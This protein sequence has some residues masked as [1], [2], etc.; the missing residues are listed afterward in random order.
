MGARNQELI[1]VWR[2]CY[3]SFG[4]E[5][6][7][8]EIGDA[9][10]TDGKAVTCKVWCQPDE[11]FRDG[12]YRL[13]G[14]YQMHPSYGNQF[15]AR[16]WIAEKPA[17]EDS[18]IAYLRQCKG[19]R[20][21]SI[22][23]RVAV[24]LYEKYGASAI[25]R[26]IASPAEAAEGISQWDASKAAIAAEFLGREEHRRC[27]KLELISLFEGRGFPKQTIDRCIKKWGVKAG[28]VVRNDPY[29][30][31]QFRGIGFLAA[32]KLY[33]EMAREKAGTDGTAYLKAL[34]AIKRQGLCLCHEVAQDRGGSTWVHGGIAKAGVRR[35]VANAN[36]D[37]DA[38]LQWAIGE[39]RLVARDENNVQW[40]A[41]ASRALHEQEISWFLGESCEIKDTNWP[42]IEEIM[43]C[44]PPGKP[45][46]S[47][48]QEHICEA[49]SLRVCC[50]QGSPGVGKTFT[51]ACIVKAII[52]Q[53][54]SDSVAVAAPTGKASVRASQALIQNGVTLDVKTVHRLL[55]VEASSSDGFR[56]HY[57]ADNHLPYKFI[58]ADEC[59]MLDVYLLASMLRA[60][61]AGTHILFVGDVNQLAPVGHGRP[62]QDMQGLIPTGHL[63]EI[64]RNSGRIV[65]A[66]AEIRDHQVF[67]PSQSLDTDAGENMPMIELSTEESQVIAVEN[68]IRNL[69]LGDSECDTTWDVQIVTAL[70]DRSG[71]SRKPL[72]LLLQGMLNADGYSVKGNP[73]RIG[74]K[75]VCLKNGTYQD[76]EEKTEE[77]F[78]A[79]GELAEVLDLKPGRMSLRLSDPPRR[80]L[81]PHAI[82]QDR[83]SG[84]SES[85]DSKGAVGDWDLGYVL[86]THRSQ[87]SQWKYVIVMIDGSGSARM[88]QTRN[89]IYT[90]IS[91][92]EVATFILGQKSICQK[93]M[94][95]DGT[96]DRKT[97][98]VEL[99][100]HSRAVR[101]VNHD[102][103]FAPV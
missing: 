96:S 61:S 91:R 9:T 45:L 8:V 21:G 67:N 53:H 18:I 49:L 36:V 55:G 83:A 14:R 69:G 74:D 2:G 77:H 71:V 68:L 58:I 60:C 103:L 13:F 28:Q 47:H 56:F 35:M 51:V 39:N 19:P 50:L 62:F 80:I 4:E 57:N 99:T 17:D 27:A 16:S 3:R 100:L 33:C 38:A 75:V 76:L 54:G 85:S 23:E 6:Q 52:E 84:E 70:N 65:M 20:N 73:F 31:M 66:C 64:Q 24:K 78:V 34:S 90:A 101:L 25:D 44:C 11:L 92:A 94:L 26:L 89:W 41:N 72:N 10:L 97:F 40:L 42:T 102:K 87:G 81:V 29:E 86:S 30:L 46:S 98:L 88:I 1:V 15:I 95:K 22:T 63:T 5:E 12:T 59:S 79:N 82:Q 32:D 43:E 7:R 37:P 93:M 48:Q